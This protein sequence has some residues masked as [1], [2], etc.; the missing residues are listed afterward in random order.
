MHNIPDGEQMARHR[1]RSRTSSP[2]AS[3][4]RPAAHLPDLLKKVAAW[5]KKLGVSGKNNSPRRLELR[6]SSR[7]SPPSRCAVHR[8]GR[9]AR[10]RQG[11]AAAL[12]QFS[13]RGL[14]HRVARFFCEARIRLGGELSSRLRGTLPEPGRPRLRGMQTSGGRNS[15]RTRPDFTI[16]RMNR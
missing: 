4:H 12:R 13:R 3:G 15:R 1:P 9:V 8:G 2:S 14:Q 5:E 10:C 6:R 11:L 7:Q 16:A